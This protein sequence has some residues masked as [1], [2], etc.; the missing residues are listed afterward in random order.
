MNFYLN[1][2]WLN[3]DGGTPGGFGKFILIP[4]DLKLGKLPNGLTKLGWL[5]KLTDGWVG[6]FP[7][8]FIDVAFPCLLA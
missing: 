6:I 7:G 1:Q 2:R 4:F 3:Q 5:G 8:R